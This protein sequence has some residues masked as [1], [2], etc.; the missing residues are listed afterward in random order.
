MMMHKILS[1]GGSI[2]SQ[3]FQEIGVNVKIGEHVPHCEE[4]GKKYFSF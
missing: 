4:R 3:N 1:E 2:I